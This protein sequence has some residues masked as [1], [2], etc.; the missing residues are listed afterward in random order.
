MGK[1]EIYPGSGVGA[2]RFGQTPAEV[3]AAMAEPRKYEEWMGGNL[4]S[5]LVFQGLILGFDRCNAEG[6][7]SSSRLVEAQLVA[8]ADASLFGRPVTA[9]TRDDLFTALCAQGQVPDCEHPKR[10]SVGALGLAVSFDEGDKL[11]H[12]ELWEPGTV[13]NG[14]PRR[15]ERQ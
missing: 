8:R 9:W 2:V 14:T 1:F 15:G 13:V 12:I 4:N 5:S 7:L 10:L 11:D 3:E 6:P